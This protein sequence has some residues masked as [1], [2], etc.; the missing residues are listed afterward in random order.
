[1]FAENLELGPSVRDHFAN[2]LTDPAEAIV[3]ETL[4]A[5]FFGDDA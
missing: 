1:M 2:E 3:N 5:N 4:L